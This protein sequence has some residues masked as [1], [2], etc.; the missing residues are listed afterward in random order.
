MLSVRPKHAKCRI[1][2]YAKYVMAWG[3]RARGPPWR[4]KL[5]FHISITLLTVALFARCFPKISN[6]FVSR[7][8]WCKLILHSS[9]DC[10][11]DI[12]L[13]KLIV[14]KRKGWQQLF[15]AV[16]EHRSFPANIAHRTKIGTPNAI[17][18]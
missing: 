8:S 2:R 11:I 5:F 15:C 3:P 7:F 16:G 10:T 13:L 18:G 6:V 17:F 14:N 12:V 1:N 4:Q 9:L